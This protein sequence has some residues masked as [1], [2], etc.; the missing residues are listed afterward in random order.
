M[1]CAIIFILYK[2]DYVWGIQETGSP[3]FSPII[4]VNASNTTRLMVK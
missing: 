3:K 1:I 2:F 4:R